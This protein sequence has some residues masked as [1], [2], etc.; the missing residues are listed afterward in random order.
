M[1]TGFW[2]GVFSLITSVNTDL[3]SYTF[4]K[5]LCKPCCVKWLRLDYYQVTSGLIVPDSHWFPFILALT[6]TLSIHLYWINEQTLEICLTWVVPY[7]KDGPQLHLVLSQDLD[8]GIQSMSFVFKSAVNK[9]CCSTFWLDPTNTECPGSREAFIPSL[10]RE[11]FPYI[12]TP[13]SFLKVILRK[14]CS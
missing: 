4:H 2:A 1:R 13:T 6:L 9:H 14:K 3:P 7:G 12:I 8:N 5:P 11:D 10:V